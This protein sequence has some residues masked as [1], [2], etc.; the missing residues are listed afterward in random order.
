MT[1]PLAW[2]ADDPC[3]GCGTGLLLLDDGPRLTVG[4]RSCGTADTWASNPDG[5]GADH[6]G[7]G[8]Q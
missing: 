6:L 4:C 7:R 3:P 8:G 5:R 2:R 1:T